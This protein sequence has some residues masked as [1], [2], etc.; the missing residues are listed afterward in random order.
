MQADADRAW[1]EG[2]AGRRQAA[3]TAAEAQKQQQQAER[4]QAYQDLQSAAA[5]R[6]KEAQLL[7]HRQASFAVIMLPC[8]VPEGSS[9]LTAQASLYIDFLLF[10]V[11]VDGVIGAAQQ[12]CM[13][14]YVHWQVTY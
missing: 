1:F 8:C 10:C 9:T 6:Q 13:S 12:I 4:K 14:C 2:E 3:Q 11:A 5:L 7:E